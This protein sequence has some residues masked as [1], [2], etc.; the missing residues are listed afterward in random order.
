MILHLTATLEDGTQGLVTG[1]ALKE[2]PIESSLFARI[3][4]RYT[5][6]TKTIIVTIAECRSG[7]M[8][9]LTNIYWYGFFFYSGADP[10][11]ACKS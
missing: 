1:E 10:P 2:G 6:V 8:V 7:S 9:I 4:I 11:I 5:S 3:P